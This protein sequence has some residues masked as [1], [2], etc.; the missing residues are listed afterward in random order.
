MQTKLKAFTCVCLV[1]IFLISLSGCGKETNK[2]NTNRSGVNTENNRLPENNN[3]EKQTEATEFPIDNPTVTES[4][5]INDAT[6]FKDGYAL[7]SL[8]DYN[9]NYSCHAVI[10][11]SGKVLS[12][13]YLPS[14]SVFYEGEGA[15]CAGS[16]DG[17]F[18]MNTST[19]YVCMDTK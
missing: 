8:G 6:A 16:L 4:F 11:K 10:D 18:Y 5:Y 2:S 17:R 13:F 9:G 7:L 12:T 1:L 15:W 3:T 14:E 19:A